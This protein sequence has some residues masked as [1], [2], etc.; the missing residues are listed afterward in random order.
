MMRRP[1]W[2]YKERD[3][4]SWGEVAFVLFIVF[5]AVIL[6]ACLLGFLGGCDEPMTIRDGDRPTTYPRTITVEEDYR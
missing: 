1:R 4:W 3:P 6:L 5:G 2:Q